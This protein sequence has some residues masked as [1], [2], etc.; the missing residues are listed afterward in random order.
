MFVGETGIARI[1]RRTADLMREGK[2]PRAE[3]AIDLATIQKY[4]NLWYSLSLDLFGGE[5]S[6]NA[7]SYFATGVKGRPQEERYEDHVALEGSVAVELVEDGRPVVREVAPRTA[8]NEFVR[9]SFVADCEKVL[10]RWNKVLAGTGAVLRLPSRRF[11]RHQGAFAG[12]AFDPDGNPLPAEELE[13]R[14][15]EFLPSEDDRRF[16]ASLMARPVTTPGHFASWIAPPQRGIDGRPADFV[17]VR[18]NEE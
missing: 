8:M 2:D 18:Y 6:T 3:G 1:V 14:R 11:H 15:G 12:H 17:Y 13:R 16:V 9:G 4:L 5:V 10:V 7:A